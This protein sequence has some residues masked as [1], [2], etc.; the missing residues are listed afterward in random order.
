MHGDGGWPGAR[1]SGPGCLANNQFAIHNDT[2]QTVEFQI[3]NTCCPPSPRRSRHSSESPS[4][5]PLNQI[6]FHTEEM[7]YKTLSARQSKIENQLSFIRR[8]EVGCQTLSTTC[9][10]GGLQDGFYFF[11]KFDK[12]KIT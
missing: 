12:S 6:Q 2:R 3:L 11:I 4:L 7:L 1:G 5:P 10:F 8:S 9:G